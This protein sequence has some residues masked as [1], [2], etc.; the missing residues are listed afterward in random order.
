MIDIESITNQIINADCMDILKQLP[1]KCIDAIICDLPY[2]TTAC[3]WDVVIPFDK[4]WEQYKRIRKDNTP[5]VLFGSEPF[6][7]LLRGSNLKEYKYDWIWNK[8]S[9]G[10]VL[11]TKYQPLKTHENIS[12]FCKEKCNYYPILEYGYESRINEKPTIKSSDMFSGIKSNKFFKTDKNKPAEARYPKSIITY[13]KQSSECCNSQS[14]HPTQKPVKLIEYLIKT[15][16]NEGDLI[17]DNCSGSGTTA[18]ACHNLKR[19]F[20]CI[21]KDKDYFDASVER[22]KNAQAQLKLF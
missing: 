17:L 21:E 11:T 1:D 15:Y 7:S 22:L 20:I 14:I 10:N 8:I 18:V 4:L 2:G 6:S 5:I 9:G 12:V 19:R 3:S 13:S 16:S